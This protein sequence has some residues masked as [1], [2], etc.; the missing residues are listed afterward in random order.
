M[1]DSLVFTLTPRPPPSLNGMVGATPR[2][3][4]SPDC[5]LYWIQPKIAHLPHEIAITSL[6]TVKDGRLLPGCWWDNQKLMHSSRI[7]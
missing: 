4:K 1:S 7:D 3:K 5:T 6:S 2:L